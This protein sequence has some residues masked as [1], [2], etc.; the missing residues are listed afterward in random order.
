MDPR[1]KPCHW[2]VTGWGADPHRRLAVGVCWPEGFSSTNA[3][4]NQPCLPRSRGSS[5]VWGWSY[6]LGGLLRLWTTLFPTVVWQGFFMK[7]L[8]YFLVISF[9]WPKNHLHGS[10]QE[11]KQDQPKQNWAD[12]EGYFHSLR[13]PSSPSGYIHQKSTLLLLAD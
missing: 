10:N 9:A 3:F 6:S 11:S 1:P 5:V 4:W 8:C 2:R 7:C 12:T 13:H